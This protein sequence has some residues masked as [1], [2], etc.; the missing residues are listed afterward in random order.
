MVVWLSQLQQIF[1]NINV[2]VSGFN[3]ALSTIKISIKYS[4]SN[5]LEAEPELPNITRREKLILHVQSTYLLW[6]LNLTRMNPSV[7]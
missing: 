5:H 7:A 2:G 4:L 1:V 6:Q 3:F